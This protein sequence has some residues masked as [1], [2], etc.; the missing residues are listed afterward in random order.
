MGGVVEMKAT[1]FVVADDVAT[2]GQKGTNA[3][4]RP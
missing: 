1:E 4:Q 3:D 2:D